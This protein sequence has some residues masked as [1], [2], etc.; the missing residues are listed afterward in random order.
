MPFFFT[1]I[2]IYNNCFMPGPFVVSHTILFAAMIILMV[3]VYPLSGKRQYKILKSCGG[4][5]LNAKVLWY[6]ASLI[7]SWF[8]AIIII[9][10]TALSGGDLK[11]LG[12]RLPSQD[13]FI[14]SRW[15]Y[16][17]SLIASALYLLYNLYCYASLRFSSKIRAHHRERLP[18]QIRLLLPVTTQE[19]RLWALLSFS[20][21]VTEEILYRG[22]LF[23]AIMLL[24]PSV[25]PYIIIVIASVLFGI[26]HLYQGRELIKPMLAGLLL[27]FIYLF[28]GSLYIVIALHILQ[29]L[30]A[31]E[32]MRPNTEKQP[33]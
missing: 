14:N 20:A 27:S 13:H 3:V 24:F 18:N 23:F 4:D 15:L 30:V 1:N 2:A 9:V 5:D 16:A 19:K 33:Q 32:I 17:A 11:E 26:G 21:G 6:K 12:F 25:S 22:Y 8:P 10:I 29:D 28:S 7:W 31:G